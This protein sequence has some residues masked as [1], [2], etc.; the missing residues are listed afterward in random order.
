[1]DTAKSDFGPLP[2]P[3]KQTRVIE[4]QDPKLKL[5]TTSKTAQGE[6]KQERAYTTD[7]QEASNPGTGP[8]W[9]SKTKWVEKELVTEIQLENQGDTVTIRDKWQMSEDGK[10]FLS[11]RNLKSSL[12]EADQKLVYTKK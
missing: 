7:G 9:K 10:S 12:G 1:M 8:A 11:L 5:S 3:E 4:H 6:T 2:A